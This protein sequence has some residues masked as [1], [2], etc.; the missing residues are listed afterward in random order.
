MVTLAIAVDG[1]GGGGEHCVGRGIRSV[2]QAF[3]PYL[4]ERGT[5]LYTTLIRKGIPTHLCV[6]GKGK[7]GVEGGGVSRL[8]SPR[9]TSPRGFL[10]CLPRCHGAV[11]VAVVQ[12][13]GVRPC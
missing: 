2:D 12:A 13:P 6:L 4:G 8:C 3:D 1:G 7:W 10:T 9:H 11:E 5:R